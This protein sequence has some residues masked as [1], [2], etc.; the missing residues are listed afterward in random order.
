MEIN[1]TNQE[2]KSIEEPF[3]YLT[4]LF[5]Y[6]NGLFSLFFA[7]AYWFLLFFVYWLFP[8]KEKDNYMTFSKIRVERWAPFHITKNL[9]IRCSQIFTPDYSVKYHM[10]Q[11]INLH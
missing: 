6:A 1:V 2:H 8:L 3:I 4:L 7:L 9:Q 10:T 5:N 11:K